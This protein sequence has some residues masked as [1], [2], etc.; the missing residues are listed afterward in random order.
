M[1]DAKHGDVIRPAHDGLLQAGV[2]GGVLDGGAKKNAIFSGGD[3]QETLVV[4]RNAGLLVHGGEL[5]GVILE[6]VEL[7]DVKVIQNDV[8]SENALGELYRAAGE[9]SHLAIFDG[10]DGDGGALVD[11]R[12]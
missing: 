4:V 3:V 5:G 1:R 2:V 8:G 6:V 7:H 12:G 11:L 10:Q 9:V